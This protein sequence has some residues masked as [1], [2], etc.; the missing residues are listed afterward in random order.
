MTAVKASALRVLPSIE[1]VPQRLL[2][3]FVDNF[4][5]LPSLRLDLALC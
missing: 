5:A 3:G 1:H 4:A 2:L